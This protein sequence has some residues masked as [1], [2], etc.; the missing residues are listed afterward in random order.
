MR[1]AELEKI[2]TGFYHH[3]HD[4]LVCTS[5]IE[6]GLDVPNANTIIIDDA[7]K[8]GLASLYQLR[9]RVGRSQRQAYA[10]FLYR[11]GK[12]LSDIAWRRLAAIRE[13]S[14][15]GSGYQVALR[16]LE[17]RG[18][19]NILGAEQ[20]GYI[21]EVG[22]DLYCQLLNEA[23]QTLQGQDPDDAALPE[24][25]LAVSAFLPADYIEDENERLTCYKRISGVTSEEALQRIA[26][27]LRDR[28]GPLPEPARNLLGIME[29][30]LWAREAH[31]ERLAQ[32]EDGLHLVFPDRS[33]LARAEASQFCAT[34]R[35][36]RR[37]D[38]GLLWRGFSFPKRTELRPLFLEFLPK[39]R[40]VLARRKVG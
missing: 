8:F 5:I 31:L 29:L 12:V 35:P 26:D 1:E 39:R 27:E 34:F 21:T 6:S 13:F 28:F 33:W 2:M 20:H 9:G 15:L 38:E 17:I 14:D 23:V 37:T 25:D 19:G 11:E 22:F 30:R 36:L 10:Y 7:D 18:A 40:S 32:N 4:V 3:K 24:A 16:D